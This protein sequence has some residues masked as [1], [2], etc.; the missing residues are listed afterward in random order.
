[1]HWPELTLAI[2]HFTVVRRRTLDIAA[3]VSEQQAS[4]RLQTGKWSVAE[5]LDH[6]LR[7]ELVFRKYQRQAVERAW[8]GKR[9]TIRI[10]FR[11][12]DTRLRP[13]PG[14][15]MPVLAPVL[16]GLHAVTPF[17]FRLAGMRTRGLVWAQAPKVAEPGRARTLDE[18]RANLR[19]QLRET[20]VLFEG[21]LPEALP[22][23]RA[24]HPLYGSNNVLQMVRLMS[25]HEER[26]QRQLRA[27]LKKL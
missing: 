5:V 9:G 24:A 11:E 15:W 4:K 2:E 12:V 16:S 13:L 6:I 21:D 7:T 19:A 26:H 22:R 18:L 8:A 17:G 20:T 23:V 1:V 10:G 14:S 27:M 25:A 3:G